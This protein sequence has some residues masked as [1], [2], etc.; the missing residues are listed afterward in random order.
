MAKISRNDP[1]PCGSGKK[2]KNCCLHKDRERYP[3]DKQADGINADLPVDYDDTKPA[4]PFIQFAQVIMDETG[5]DSE[6]GIN[7]ALCL[8][9]II[10][11]IAVLFDEKKLQQEMINKFAKE[12]SRILPEMSKEDAR[13]L[14]VD[15]LEKFYDMFPDYKQI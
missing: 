12:V 11:N 3:I 13:Q 6:E 10:H 14:C 8:S 4:S 15:L 2:Y 1:C 7:K 5:D 9:Q